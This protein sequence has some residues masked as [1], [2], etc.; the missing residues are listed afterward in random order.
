MAIIDAQTARIQALYHLASKVSGN[1]GAQP[2]RWI[3][4]ASLALAPLL[5]F[6]I[7]NGQ[8]SDLLL[9]TFEVEQRGTP[10]GFIGIYADNSIGTSLAFI[11]IKEGLPSLS[12]NR[13]KLAATLGLDAD[14]LFPVV[15]SFPKI[16]FIVVG[17][18]V[19][20]YD[21]FDFQEI[22]IRDLVSV[23]DVQ[24]L[25]TWSLRATLP[26]AGPAG[27]QRWTVENNFIAGM[28]GISKAPLSKL[29]QLQ[30]RGRTMDVILFDTSS[31]NDGE[32][33]NNV[34]DAMDQQRMQVSESYVPITL[35]AQSG[36]INCAAASCQM[37]YE[38]VYR[39]KIDQQAVAAA[40][41]VSQEQAGTTPIQ[42]VAEYKSLF[43]N[44]FDVDLEMSPSLD[45][46]TVLL[47]LCLPVKCAIQGHARVAYGIRHNTIIDPVSGAV[48]S[49]EVGALIADP[50]PVG[51]GA[52]YWENILMTTWVDFISLRRRNQQY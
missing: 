8:P 37:I 11:R 13:A 17:A 43:G 35:E 49:R 46:L 20:L 14:K 23:S 41:H 21:A 15:Y 42:Q 7:K 25:I 19:A 50:Y 36:P 1:Y 12:G 6:D 22:Q 51:S 3:G 27:E 26:Q 16:G 34:Q 33:I 32:I 52:L 29:T 9:Y 18:S 38:Y 5:I 28:C 40:M 31:N 2:F 47:D 39:K 10:C 45:K 30:V 44:E 4:R 24:G 48:Q